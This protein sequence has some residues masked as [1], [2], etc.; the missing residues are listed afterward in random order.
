MEFT[1]VNQL[2]YTQAVQ[3][4]E[5]ILNLMQSDNCDIDSL[6]QFTTRAAELL[7]A[8][9]ERLMMTDKELQ[10]I[11]AELNPTQSAQ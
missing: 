5:K 4:L 1:P 7:K 11:L 3:E 10:K 8:C 9:R 2:S 6:S